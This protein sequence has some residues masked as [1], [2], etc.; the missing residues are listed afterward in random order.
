MSCP[1]TSRKASRR[2]RSRRPPRRAHPT[3]KEPSNILIVLTI[4][5]SRNDPTGGEAS[6]SSLHPRIASPTGSGGGEPT[7]HVDYMNRRRGLCMCARGGRVVGR[8]MRAAQSENCSGRCEA[9]KTCPGGS[10]ECRP[11]FVTVTMRDLPLHYFVP[12]VEQL[13]AQG[14]LVDDTLLSGSPATPTFS[15]RRSSS[16]AGS[17]SAAGSSTAEDNLSAI[18]H[19]VGECVPVLAVV[20]GRSPATAGAVRRTVFLAW[21]AEP[22]GLSWAGVW[23]RWC[24]GVSLVR[25]RAGRARVVWRLVVVV[26]VRGG[27]AGC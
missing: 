21:H 24:G 1:T 15:R 8:G 23:S 4:H 25:A 7:R 22:S 12:A 11:V 13:L 6:W 17:L 27:G 19:V 14:R 16:S 20:V 10:Q 2:R 26:V 5:F 3:E 18:E 9:P